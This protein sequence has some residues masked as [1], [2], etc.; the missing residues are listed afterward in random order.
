MKDSDFKILVVDDSDALRGMLK[1]FFKQYTE[2]QIFEAADGLKALNFL[3]QNDVHLIIT[4]IVMPN[5]DGLSLLK[6]IK[7][8]KPEVPIIVISGYNT[9]ANIETAFKYYAIKFYSKPFEWDDLNATIKKAKSIYESTSAAKQMSD[10][11]DVRI[12]VKIEPTNSKMIRYIINK[13]I[14][15]ITNLYM[16]N[17]EQGT[18]IYVLL[19]EFFLLGKNFLR[20]L[21]EDSY[22][23]FVYN[24]ENSKLE[25]TIE[26][27]KSELNFR[28]IIEASNIE[29]IGGLRAYAD[30]IQF[31]N[32]GKKII[33]IKNL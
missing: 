5:L 31:A 11:V 15:V 18:K 32:D 7:Y 9:L 17:Y 28:N 27:S 1:Q 13:M 30:D 14:E 6:Q 33:V 29:L 23:T 3:E 22:L 4:D 10:A 26:D 16:I 25:F 19:T 12:K 2:Y 20:S 21:S 8:K 24:Q